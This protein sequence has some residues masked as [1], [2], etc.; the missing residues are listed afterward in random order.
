MKTQVPLVF[1]AAC[2]A[3]LAP[4]GMP[5]VQAKAQI[6]ECSVKPASNAR[7]HW[8]W[9][10]IDGRKCW[11]AGKA[12][13]PKSSLR[14]AAVAPSQAKVQAKLDVTPVVVATAPV[15]V[16]AEKRSDPMDAQA[17]ML[18]ADNT[19][20]ARWRARVSSE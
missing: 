17:R 8:S 16:A 15:V 13:I 4:I 1:F 11:Y 6:K 5:T 7:G 19:F 18:D 10:L 3:A 9:R 20:E 12:V 14:W 2:I